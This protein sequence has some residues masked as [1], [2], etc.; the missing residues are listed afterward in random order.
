MDNTLTIKQLMAL[1]RYARY[2]K[3]QGVARSTRRYILSN[4]RDLLLDAAR[5]RDEEME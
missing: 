3:R 5:N 4:Y 1:L 2:L